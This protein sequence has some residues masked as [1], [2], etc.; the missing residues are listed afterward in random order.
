MMGGEEACH[1]APTVSEKRAVEPFTGVIKQKISQSLMH[2]RLAAEEN[3]ALSCRRAAICASSTPARVAP[4]TVVKTKRS[5]PAAKTYTTYIYQYVADGRNR[6]CAGQGGVVY[7]RR[8]YL[9]QNATLHA[10]SCTGARWIT[11]C[12]LSCVRR[13]LFRPRNVLDS[14]CFIQLNKIKSATVVCFT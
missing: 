10:N 14:N 6:E 11:V 5:F 1:D 12:C 8:E 2:V 13:G 7:A 3:S 4:K 9:V